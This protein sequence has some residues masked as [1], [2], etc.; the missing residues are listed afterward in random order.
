[1]SNE[2]YLP[3]AADAEESLTDGELLVLR[4]QYERELP[5][6]RI[7]TKFN[8]AWGLIKSRAKQEQKLGVALMHEIF[9]ENRERQRECVYYLAI[10]HYKLGTYEDARRFVELLLELEPEN[11]QAQSLRELIN[12]KVAREGLIGLALSGGAIALA[13]IAIAALFRRSK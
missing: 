12:E 6:V 2:K 7:Q 5:Q 10:G 13:G 4:R 11:A 9:N 1:M 3:Y 8:Y